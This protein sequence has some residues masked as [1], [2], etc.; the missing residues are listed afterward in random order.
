ML[1]AQL[2]FWCEAFHLDSSR[3]GFLSGVPRQVKSLILVLSLNT[4]AVGYFIVFLTGYLPQEGISSR[5][6]GTIVGAEGITMVIAGIPLG[7]L[8]DRK[9]RKW[10]LT[11]S[12]AG[13]SPVLFILAFT[14]NPALLIFS[15]IIAGMAEGGFLST[16]NATI[17]DQTP[18]ASRNSAFS[19]SF[20]LSTIFSGLG[21][22]LSFIFPFLETLLGFTSAEMHEDVLIIFGSLVIAT[23]FSLFFLL[24][25]YK[26]KT[27][28]D[29]I[30]SSPDSMKNLVKFSGANS[31]IGL[32]AGFIIPLIATWFFLKFGISDNY[33]GPLLA[34]SNITMGMSALLSPR[35]SRRFGIVRAIAINQ[36]LSTVFMISLA[37]VGGPVL[38]ASLYV[39]RAALMNMSSP[40]SDSFLMGLVPKERR[41]L[42]S[43]INSVVWRLPN[44]VTTIIGGAILA[45][46]NYSLPFELAALF[47]IIAISLFYTFFKDFEISQTVS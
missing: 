39:I 18:T 21:L 45:S 28:Q 41:G 3:A 38:A 44:S 8:S 20:L 47:Y 43:A 40:L 22:S 37:F 2:G 31:L 26:E 15:G 16:V 42:A 11:V 13:L 35:M 24:R 36:G 4:L 10:I 12:A 6:I 25:N 19:F 7:L 46:G 5:L 14:R 33:S 23:P 29:S 34:I 27:S 30:A 17:A 1:I 32:G 9:G